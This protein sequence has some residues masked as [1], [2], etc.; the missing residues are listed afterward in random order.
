LLRNVTRG[1]NSKNTTNRDLQTQIDQYKEGYQ[2]KTNLVK[3]VNGDLLAGT[4][5]IC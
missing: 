1:T 2:P 4:H 5:N 3:D